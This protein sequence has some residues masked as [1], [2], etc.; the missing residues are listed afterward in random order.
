MKVVLR[1]EEAEHQREGEEVLE[2]IQHAVEDLD[3]RQDMN[4]VIFQ[5]LLNLETQK[6]A[7]KLKGY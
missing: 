7:N 6:K 4:C 5:N 3:S 1:V 2:E